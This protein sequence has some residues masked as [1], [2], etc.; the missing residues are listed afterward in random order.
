MHGRINGRYSGTIGRGRGRE[1]RRQEHAF[2]YQRTDPTMKMKT[3]SL[4]LESEHN[5]QTLTQFWEQLHK[6]F[7]PKNILIVHVYSLMA[8]LHH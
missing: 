2:K 1:G 8:C 5:K 4:G 3:A 6:E 7:S